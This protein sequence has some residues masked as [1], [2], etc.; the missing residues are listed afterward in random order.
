M[1][2]ED[3]EEEGGG[4]EERCLH[5]AGVRNKT[6]LKMQEGV[7]VCVVDV[8][9]DASSQSRAEDPEGLRFF[10]I[11]SVTLSLS[12]SLRNHSASTQMP[13]KRVENNE[14]LRDRVSSQGQH[15]SNSNL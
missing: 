8:T 3:Y 11:H 1:G 5:G 7:C 10:C 9:Y 13:E 14:N 6:H 4:R 12:V 15:R 2:E